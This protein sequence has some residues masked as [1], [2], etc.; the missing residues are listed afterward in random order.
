[1]LNFYSVKHG[2]SLEC[3]KFLKSQSLLNA[4]PDIYI[5]SDYCVDNFKIELLPR[6]IFQLHLHVD[7]GCFRLLTRGFLMQSELSVR[8]N[9]LLWFFP[10]QQGTHVFYFEKNVIILPRHT[11]LM[12]SSS[13]HEKQIYTVV[14]PPP[15]LS[16][17]SLSTVSLIPGQPW[18]KILSEKFQKCINYKF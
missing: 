15:T 1:M 3:D 8:R 7:C 13:E 4:N 14:L 16:V 9:G 18:S 5:S 6:G 11:Q 2:F 17:G 12:A 10:E